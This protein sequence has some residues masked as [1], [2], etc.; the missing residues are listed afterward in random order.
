MKLITIIISTGFMKIKHTTFICWN[1][2]KTKGYQE[3][4]K[5]GDVNL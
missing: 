5:G 1:S 2:M 4:Y 3:G